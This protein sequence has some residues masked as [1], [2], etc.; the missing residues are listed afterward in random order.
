MFLEIISWVAVG[1][2]LITSTAILIARDWRI[3]LGALAF[4]YLALFWLVTRHLPPAMGSAKLIAG[5]MAVTVLG[6][7]RIGHPEA[8]EEDDFWIHWGR[9]GP[10]FE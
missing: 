2:M 9:R 8:E 10:P 1:M 5:W 6:M 4:Q 3:G 7:T